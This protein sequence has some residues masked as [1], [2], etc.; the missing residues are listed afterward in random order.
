MFVSASGGAEVEHVFDVDLIDPFT[1]VNLV[2]LTKLNESGAIRNLAI[3]KIEET[4]EKFEKLQARIK[5]IMM[6]FIAFL[7]AWAYL[8]MM[9]PIAN[10]AIDAIMRMQQ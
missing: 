8:S 10:Q 3:Y 4:V 6:L 5:S 2:D 7:I 1:R 9:G